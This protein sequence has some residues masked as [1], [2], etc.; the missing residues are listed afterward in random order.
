MNCDKEINVDEAR[1]TTYCID[2]KGAA[3]LAIMFAS[4]W[5]SILIFSA[6]YKFVASLIG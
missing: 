2:W 4:T 3:L 5:A 1:R 6:G